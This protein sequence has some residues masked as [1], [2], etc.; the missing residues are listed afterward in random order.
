[1]NTSKTFI[2][3]QNSDFKSPVEI[4]YDI[5]KNNIFFMSTF[6]GDSEWN[7]IDLL[8]S[9]NKL[10]EYIEN[11][12][13]L[14]LVNGARKNTWASGFLR[15]SSN[16]VGSYLYDQ[17]ENVVINIFDPCDKDIVTYI[18][19]REFYDKWRENKRKTS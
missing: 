2:K 14:I 18:Q 16:G 10:R 17:G 3:K 12:G 11:Q 4:R 9:F 13:Y 15:S 8:D 5:Q 7:G 6:L 19:Q 1:M